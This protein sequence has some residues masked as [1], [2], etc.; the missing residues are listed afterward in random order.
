[1]NEHCMPDHPIL[2][3]GPKQ[4]TVPSHHAGVR[5]H[6]TVTECQYSSDG[7]HLCPQKMDMSHTHHTQNA[8]NPTHPSTDLP[9]TTWQRLLL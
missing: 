5:L 8:N 2:N 3:A 4:Y 6:S 7:L 9:Q 1:M